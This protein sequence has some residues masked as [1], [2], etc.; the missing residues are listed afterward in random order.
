M[1]ILNRSFTYVVIA[2]FGFCLIG[3]EPKDLRGASIEQ[4]LEK[5]SESLASQLRKA[6]VKKLTILDLVDADK[7]PIRLG[8]FIAEETTVNLVSSTNTFIVVDRANLDKILEEH[9]LSRTGLENPEDLKKLGR[10]SGVNAIVTGT[11]TPLEDEIRFTAKVT[12]TETADILGAAKGRIPKSPQVLRMIEVSEPVHTNKPPVVSTNA[13]GTK[14]PD[15]PPPAIKISENSKQ[16]GDLLLE[17]ESLRLSGDNFEGKLLA[18][19]V[20]RNMS[21]EKTLAVGIPGRGGG[22]FIPAI[23]IYNDRGDEFLMPVDSISGIATEIQRTLSEIPPEGTLV[24]TVRYYIYWKSRAGNYGPYR[25][26]AE[27]LVDESDRGRLSNTKKA[28][29]VINV[30]TAK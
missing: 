29:F 1:S 10:F 3:A 2:C 20:F 26:Q 22:V 13:P 7:R 23:S 19:L 27:V 24:A 6:G 5:F 28:H 18:T 30:A 12:S 14:N 25:V 15:N 9:K 11:I 21:S 4:E 17:V 8:S 16:I